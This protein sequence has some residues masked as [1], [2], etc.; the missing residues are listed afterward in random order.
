MKAGLALLCLLAAI[1]GGSSA[2]VKVDF[3]KQF[4]KNEPVTK[5][6]RYSSHVTLSIE[7]DDGSL[8][9]SGWSTRTV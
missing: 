9:P 7:N 4:P 5:D 2:D 3:I 6:H 1:T 8:T